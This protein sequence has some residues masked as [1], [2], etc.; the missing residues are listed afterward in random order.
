MK[1]KGMCLYG[2]RH[3]RSATVHV[4]I[5]WTICDAKSKKVNGVRYRWNKMESKFKSDFDVFQKNL[6]KSG[7]R[8]F[9]FSP[10][11]SY[12]KALLAFFKRKKG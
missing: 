12:H 5:I 8:S 11:D 1:K 10:D 4:H 7:V 3:R 9:S 6:T 2:H